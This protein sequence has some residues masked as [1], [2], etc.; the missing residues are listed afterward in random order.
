MDTIQ[1]DILSRHAIPWHRL[2]VQ[3]Y[4]RLGEAGVLGEDDRVELLEGLLVDMAPIGPRHALVT[5]LL[6]ELLVMAFAGRAR[7]RVKNPVVLNDISEPQPDFAVVRRYEPG[8]PLAHPVPQDTFLLVEV[9]D[10]SLAFDRGFKLE[11][12]AKAGI[13]EVWIVDLTTNGVLVHRR[14]SGGSYQSV[15]RVE[16][17]GILSVEAL[18]GVTIRVADLFL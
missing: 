9:S 2:T 1:P 13:R 10:S 4:H 8:A 7:V 14:P 17:A 11:I 18:L 15:I 16:G 5:D 12:Y 3:D 6:T